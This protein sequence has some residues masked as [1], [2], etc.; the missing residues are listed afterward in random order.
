MRAVCWL[1]AGWTY[2]LGQRQF[3][4][5]VLGRKLLIVE[6]SGKFRGSFVDLDEKF[7]VNDEVAG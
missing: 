6:G 2:I 1:R 7:G 3:A 4:D 5:D